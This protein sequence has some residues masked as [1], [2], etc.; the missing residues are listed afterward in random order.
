MTDKDKK[1]RGLLNT[2]KKNITKIENKRTH[3]TI[4]EP[5]KNRKRNNSKNETKCLD[6][7]FIKAERIKRFPCIG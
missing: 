6:K 4:N 7:P 2:F 1:P 5:L 3:D